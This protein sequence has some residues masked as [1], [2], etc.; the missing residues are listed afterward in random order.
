MDDEG[1]GDRL[2]AERA[3]ADADAAAARDRLDL[4]RLEPPAVRLF[5]LAPGPALSS[6]R[7]GATGVSGERHTGEDECRSSEARNESAVSHGCVPG[8]PRCRPRKSS[9]P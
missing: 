3:A 8:I 2:I 1:A 5:R 4:E 7:P 6:R 9:R